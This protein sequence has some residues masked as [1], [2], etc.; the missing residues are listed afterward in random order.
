MRD[1]LYGLAV[2]YAAPVAALLWRLMRRKG[3]LS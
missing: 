1:L 2:I 3:D